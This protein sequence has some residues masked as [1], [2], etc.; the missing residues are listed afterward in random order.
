MK[1]TKWFCFWLVLLFS[2]PA[3]AQ[4]TISITGLVK[5]P[6]NMTLENLSACQ[7]VEAQ[8]NGI[9]ED[10]RYRGVFRYR[11]VPLRDLL[12]M[13]TI[14]KEET[15]FP[16]CVDL[17][18]LVRNKEGRQVALSW[19]EVFYRN[20]G[21]IL[22]AVSGVPIIPRREC[23]KCHTK[24]VY[25]PRLNQ[26]H[27]KIGYPKLV[28]AADGY[29]DR[30]LED[31]TNIEV[32]DLRPRMPKKKSK[33]LFSPEFTVTGAVPAPKTFQDLSN[34]PK[35]AVRMKLVGEGD[36]YHGMEMLEGVSL[37][38]ILG[39]AKISPRLDQVFLASAPDGYR[40]LFSYGEI[41]LDPDG[42]R[43]M[44]ADRVNG[45]PPKKGGVFILAAPDDLM[46]NRE[47]KA[48]RTIEA[49]SLG[50]TP[51]INIIGVGCGDTDLITLEAVSRMAAMDTFV[52]PPDIAKRFAKYM[53]NKAILMDLYTLA[54]PVLK[55]QNPTLSPAELKKLMA[56]KRTAAAATIRSALKEGKT[57]GVLEYGDPT[58]WSGSRWLQEIFD[59]DLIRL[60][61]GVGSF[62]VSNALM[63]TDVGCNG[64]VVAATPGGL[65]DNPD[66]V[67]SLAEKG[68]TLC[69]F[70]GLKHLDELTGF[71]RKWYS[72]ETPAYL[73]YKAGYSASE[74]IRSAT[75]ENIVE[76]AHEEK[77]K[78][79]GLIYVG[80]CLTRKVTWECK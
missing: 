9:F 35:K 23:G 58:I 56:K 70:M 67:K 69:I 78:F 54:P 5:Q 63:K 49:I 38:T 27:R 64:A 15:D 33:E 22:V 52:C 7:S 80:P 65:K 55:K 42:D 3:W 45:A 77:E 76:T 37:K 75:L 53:V 34:Y 1:K 26:L 31:I 29:A 19:G 36:G 57:V 24:E 16:K 59:R 48:L 47:V 21:R 11:G 18:I 12:E 8:L 79:L 39:D 66:L 4:G 6:L 13:A 68:E 2:V 20:P 10:G 71:L 17:A 14:S 72:P 30:S 73:V 44:V 50:R 32:V 74:R 62:N 41:F 51:G 28:V 46:A 60:V 61:P 43:L 25:E 40:A